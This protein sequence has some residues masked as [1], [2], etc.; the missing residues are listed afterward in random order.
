M[1]CAVMLLKSGWL[2]R[3]ETAVVMSIGE[4]CCGGCAVVTSVE[5]EEVG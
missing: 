5:S 4:S 2:L 1:F 3:W